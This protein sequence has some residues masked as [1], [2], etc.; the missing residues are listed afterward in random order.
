[1]TIAVTGANSSV[2][3]N[4]LA[5]IVERGDLDAIGCVRSQRVAASLPESPRITARIV[6]YQNADGLEKALDGVSCVVHLAGILIESKASTYESANVASAA[7]VAEAARAA[8]VQHI[9]LVSVIGASSDS[10]NRYLRSKGDAERVVTESELSATVLRTPILLGVGTAGAAAILRSASRGKTRLLGG[11]RYTVR[12]L[13]LDDLSRAILLAC[14]NQPTGAL[15]HELVGPDAVQYRELIALTAGLLDRELSIGT[16]PVWIA[17][18][19]A[20]IASRVSGGG[21]SPTVIDVITADEVVETNADAALGLTL[22]PL[23]TT[24]EKIV[25]DHGRERCQRQLPTSPGRCVSRA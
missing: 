14:V 19:G 16:M 2:G 13:D 7:A 17:K 23:S 4:L 12:P 6:S 18:A 8:G 21:V 5:H 10:P 22:T 3:L 24:L 9:V 20:A 1:M 11:G 25:S 15:V